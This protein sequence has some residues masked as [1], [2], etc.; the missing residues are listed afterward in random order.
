MSVQPSNLDQLWQSVRETYQ[1]IISSQLQEKV[2]VLKIIFI[3]ISIF[4]IF[5]LIYFLLKSCYLK[6][7]YLSD[8]Q[9]LSTFKHMEVK[10]WVKRWKKIK[11]RSEK[12]SPTQ[13]KLSLIEAYKMLDEVLRRIGYSGENINERLKKVKEGDIANL[14]QVREA[15]QVCQDIIR[16][17]DYRLDKKKAEE[18]IDIFEETFKSLQVF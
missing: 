17:P 9:D 2:F 15:H 10:K 6:D 18:I 4:F 16:D 11:A 5:W 13:Q 7:L 12:G 14:S 8:L 1:F 3:L